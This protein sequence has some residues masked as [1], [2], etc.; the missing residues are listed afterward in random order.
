MISILSKCR[1]CPRNCDV[2]RL[3]NEKGFCMAA[4]NPKV[5]RVSLHHFEEPCIS[6]T[7]GSGTVFFSECNLSCVF[8]Q[9]HSISENH[10]GKEI[11]IKRLSRI[12]L[13][14]QENGAHNIN[15]VTPTHYVPQIIE[16]LD[17]A[18]A[19]GLCIPIIYNTS[20][21]EN[22]ETIKSLKGYIDIYLPDLKYYNDKF[23]IKYSNAPNYFKHASL[24]I[25]EMVNQIGKCE[26]DENGIIKKGVIIRHMMLPGLLFDSKK[27]IDYIYNRFN[28]LVYVSI[29]NQYTPLNK[30]KDY[31]E[32]NKPV[33]P[34]V[35]ESFIDYCISMGIT[36]GFIQEEGTV[37]ESFVPKFDMRGV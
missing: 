31:P 23:A 21:Y 3:N 30:A 5:A 20:S 1:L 10:V 7:N 28:D 14:Q 26:F 36:Q 13:E 9:N 24:A 27:I 4:I 32:I 19:N 2:N 29:M 33:N 37:K 18:K 35:Y 17:I 8:C 25:E 6:G 16:A 12:F 15:L 22:L 34:K 11:S